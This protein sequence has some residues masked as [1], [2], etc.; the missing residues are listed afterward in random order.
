MMRCRQT[1]DT[2]LNIGSEREVGFTMNYGDIHSDGEQ[3][4]K[5]KFWEKIMTLVFDGI[6]LI[7]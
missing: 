2:E 6:P 4:K 7:D 5:N 1:E 3:Q